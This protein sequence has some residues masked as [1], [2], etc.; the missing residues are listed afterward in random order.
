MSSSSED[1]SPSNPTG[2]SVS[3]KV[4]DKSKKDPCSS[5]FYDFRCPYTLRKTDQFRYM[6]QLWTVG[7]IVSLNEETSTRIFYAQILELHENDLCEK[8]AKIVW[9]GPKANIGVTDESKKV[10]FDTFQPN[11]FAH[12]IVDDRLVPI[13]CLTFVMNVPNLFEYK[14]HIGIDYLVNTYIVSHAERYAESDEDDGPK[15]KSKVRRL[16]NK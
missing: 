14:K 12:I 8:R 1:D 10:H 16:L 6:N 15:S 3:K 11:E 9:L 7:D 5:T 2:V 13:H 4:K